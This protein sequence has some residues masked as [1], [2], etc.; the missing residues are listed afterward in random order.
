MKTNGWERNSDFLLAREIIEKLYRNE[1]LTKQ[2]Y[3]TVIR[4]LKEQYRPPIEE[5]MC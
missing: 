1:L 4:K 2:E 3:K 5:L